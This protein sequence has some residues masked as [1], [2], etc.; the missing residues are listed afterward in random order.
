MTLL[1]NEDTGVSIT[2]FVTLEEKQEVIR[3]VWQTLDGA[4]YMQRYG[5]PNVT[6]DITA[7]VDPTGKQALMAAEDEAS[8]LKI[9]CK[10]GTFYGRIV[11]LGKFDRLAGDW[12]KTE[13]TLAPEVTDS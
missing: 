12:F 4:T 9:V 10:R 5:E 1:K 11:E 7:Y 2:R 8:L 3:T 13:L 6:Y